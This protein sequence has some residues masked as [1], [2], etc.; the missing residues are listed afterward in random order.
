MK[1]LLTAITELIEAR[2]EQ[3]RE[4][5]STL[6]LGTYARGYKDGQSDIFEGAEVVYTTETDDED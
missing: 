2:A 4:E 6:Q 3:V 1:R 5:T